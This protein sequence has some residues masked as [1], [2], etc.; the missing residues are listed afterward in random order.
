LHVEAAGLGGGGGDHAPA[1]DGHRVAAQLGLVALPDG[2][3]ERTHLLVWHGL[4]IAIL[5][6]F[7]AFNL[8]ILFLEHAGLLRLLYGG[9]WGPVLWLGQVLRL[10]LRDAL[11]L[12]SI[13][14]L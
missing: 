8:A 12:L 9:L 2:R 7:A 11:A 4:G 5:V 13:A 14:L 6:V 1:D 3:V 10:N